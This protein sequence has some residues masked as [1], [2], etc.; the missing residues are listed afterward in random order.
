MSNT[1]MIN[2]AV[3]VDTSSGE[4]YILE[5]NQ[6]LDFQASMEHSLLCTNQARANGVIIEYIPQALDYT[7][8]SSHSIIFPEQN[9]Q[10][11]LD[12]NGPTSHLHVRY[13]TDDEMIDCPH[14]EL[15]SSMGTI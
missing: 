4:T 5:I 1:R 14:L 11:P 7:G 6:A 12:R 3:A 8:K 9:I 15:T 2:G 10:F 13:P